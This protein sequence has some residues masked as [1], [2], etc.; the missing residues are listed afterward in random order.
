MTRYQKGAAAERELLNTLYD[1]GYAVIRAA[2]SGVNALGPD[3][4]VLKGDKAIAFECKSGYE[5]GL[6][7]EEIQYQKI[8][9][10]QER[11]KF[12]IYVAWRITREGWFFMHPSE[13]RKTDTR[14]VLTQKE[15]RAINR[16]LESVL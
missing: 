2:G 9:E 15:A 12:P 14:R 5:G 6:S 3:I 4:V 8:V 16:G 1:K 10:W 7:I 13:L 11:S